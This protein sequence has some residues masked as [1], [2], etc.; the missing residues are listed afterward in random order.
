MKASSDCKQKTTYGFNAHIA[1]EEDNFIKAGV[2]TAG[3]IHDSQCLLPLLSGGESAI[4]A[5]SAFKSEKHD[6]LLEAQ[7]T[8]NCILERAY[9]NKQLTD[10]QK[11][12]SAD[13]IHPL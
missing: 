7:D 10:V 13:W 11:Q 4:H 3:N 12:R 1:V 9:R 2:F 6:A 5:D 8:K